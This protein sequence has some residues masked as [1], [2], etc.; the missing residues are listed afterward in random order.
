MFGIEWIVPSLAMAYLE[1]SLR[2]LATL[3]AS[4]GVSP[5]PGHVCL[6]Y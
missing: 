4:E 5:S 2:F 6:I 1:D 3:G